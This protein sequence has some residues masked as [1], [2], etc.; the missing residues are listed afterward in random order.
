MSY[1]AAISEVKL[2]SNK[3]KKRVNNGTC[4]HSIR[5]KNHNTNMSL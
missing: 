1:Y 3:K 5:R 2:T 4:R